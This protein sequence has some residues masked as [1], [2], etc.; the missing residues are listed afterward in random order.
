MYT[1]HSVVQASRCLEYV[2]KGN[3]MWHNQGLSTTH[4]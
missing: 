4:D 1:K 2:S 3:T